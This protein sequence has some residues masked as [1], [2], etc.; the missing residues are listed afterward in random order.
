MQV[1]RTAT[2]ALG[3]F[4]YA[5]QLAAHGFHIALD[6]SRK[7][8]LSSDDPSAGARLLYTQDALLG[9]I[10]SRSHDHP[11]FDVDPG[12]LGITPGSRFTFNSVGPLWFANASAGPQPAE[13]GVTMLIRSQDPAI[14]SDLEIR[15]NSRFQVGFLIGAFDGTAIGTFE[16][17]LEY[18][19]DVPID[20]AFPDGLPVGAYAISLQLTGM[21]G[22]GQP[23]VPSDP[24][25][26]VFN[27]KLPIGILPGI[28]N[29][30]YAVIAV[31]EPSA[32]A[33]ACAALG[34]VVWAAGRRRQ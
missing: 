33:L 20:P 19:L 24:F 23:F 28:A 14:S 12:Q 22:A 2:I 6:A 8:Q 15:R 3:L 29:Q 7:L 11:G 27:N 4:A 5:S 21:D 10:Y 30:L 25:V 1:L 17:Q 34:A 18:E 31:P 26:I 9:P 32:F 16:H 13:T